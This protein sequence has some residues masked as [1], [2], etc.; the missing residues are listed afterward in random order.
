MSGTTVLPS[1]KVFSHVESPENDAI[2][3]R[4]RLESVMWVHFSAVENIANS[5]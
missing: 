4:R 3:L 5:A 2:L 1:E